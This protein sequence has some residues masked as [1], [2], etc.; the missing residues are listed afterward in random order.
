[1]MYYKH[2]KQ[3]QNDSVRMLMEALEMEAQKNPFWTLQDL[4]ALCRDISFIDD[5]PQN[6]DYFDSTYLI[7]AELYSEF[8]RYGQMA[9]VPESLRRVRSFTMDEASKQ[10]MMSV[11]TDL[12]SGTIN[13]R[14][15]VLTAQW[16]KE[17]TLRDWQQHIGELAAEIMEAVPEQSPANPDLDKAANELEAQSKKKRSKKMTAL[18]F[19]GSLLFTWFSLYILLYGAGVTYSAV[20][21]RANGIRTT[22]EVTRIACEM[23]PGKNGSVR[24]PASYSY[25]EVVNFTTE[26]GREVQSRLYAKGESEDRYPVGDEVEIYYNPEAP[27][28]ITDA[29]SNAQL[30]KGI[31]AIGFGLL[32]F[33]VIAVMSKGLFVSIGSLGWIASI[34]SKVVLLLLALGLLVYQNLYTLYRYF[35]AADEEICVDSDGVMVRRDDGKPFSGR[36]QSHTDQSLSVYSYKNGQLDGL[37][38]V[39]YDGIV[40]ET[41]HWKDGK[42][43]G[44]FLLYTPSGILV[45]YANFENGERHGLT[46]QFDPETGGITVE[47]SYNN[48]QLDGTWTQ[49]YPDSGTI[50]MEQTYQNGILNGPARQY[51]EDGQL[52]IDMSYVD[53]IP[54]GPY[55]SYYPDGQI[56]IDGALENGSYSSDTKMYD[57]NGNPMDMYQNQP[58]GGDSYGDPSDDDGIT[59]TE[60]PDGDSIPV[61]YAITDALQAAFRMWVDPETDY[62]AEFSIQTGDEV[63]SKFYEQG[64][65]GAGNIISELE[66]AENKILRI[67]IC[68]TRRDT[69]RYL[70]QGFENEDID[71]ET[72]IP[73]I[74]QVLCWNE[75]DSEPFDILIRVVSESDGFPENDLD[76]YLDSSSGWHDLNLEP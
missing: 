50:A 75:P 5:D 43:N 49:Y 44:L 6:A 15:R 32:I 62:P 28:Q 16:E 65:D 46:Q 27:A 7:L 35:P 12:G 45:D 30:I 60:I 34:G 67:D 73:E 10:E 8:K 63:I 56:G 68:H 54:S 47:G 1:M 55:K 57:E 76:S 36:M 11:L 9:D 37:D 74:L 29:S 31:A 51:Y 24:E 39:Y 64:S 25:F 71:A 48:G 52:Q 61:S 42:Q 17:G 33:I 38:V 69:S 19:V 72:L 18:F 22:A 66:L 21:L 20:N 13:N 2:Y 23:R 4:F 41:G 14:T 70:L 26:S 40:K 59:I 58:D 3:T 53:G